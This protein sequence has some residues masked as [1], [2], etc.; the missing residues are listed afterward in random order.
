MYLHIISG[1]YSYRELLVSWIYRIIR[2]RYNQSILGGLWAVLHPVST[3]VIFSI[4]FTRIVPVDTGGTPYIVFSYTAM[5]PW[6]FFSTSITDMAESLVTNMNLV[7]KIYFPRDILVIA[8]LAARFIDFLIAFSLLIV[9]LYIYNM[10]LSILGW[11]F[12]PVIVLIQSIL[13]LGIG[14]Y[15][16]AINVYY[17]DVRHL[18]ALGLQLLFYLTP[19]IYPVSLV[20][21][22]LRILYFMNPMA[23]IVEAY[24]AIIIHGTLPDSTLILSAGIALVILLSGYFVFKKLEYQFADVI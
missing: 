15:G 19:I 21:D 20:P 18:I 22:H 13:A 8:C 7:A 9:L 16:A 24:R 11:L 12:L 3:V 23:G 4:I 17:R 1:I 5:V 6:I 14:L 2:S 10:P